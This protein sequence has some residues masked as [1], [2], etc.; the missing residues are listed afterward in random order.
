M[1]DSKTEVPQQELAPC[2]K[3]YI[4]DMNY[5]EGSATQ[6]VTQQVTSK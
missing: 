3:K 1:T 2:E 6:Q 5:V 4:E